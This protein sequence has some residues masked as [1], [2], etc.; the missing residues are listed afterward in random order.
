MLK[1]I[2]ENVKNSG[3]QFYEA[4]D[5]EIAVADTTHLRAE[6]FHFGVECFGRGVCGSPTEVVQDGRGMGFECLDN[7]TEVIVGQC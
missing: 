1:C 5:E 2:E 7:R 6:Y 3:I 4:E